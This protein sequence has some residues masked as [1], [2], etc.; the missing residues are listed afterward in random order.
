MVSMTFTDLFGFMAFFLLPF[1]YLN[2]RIHLNFNYEINKPE[3]HYHCKS[4]TVRSDWI[5]L[6]AYTQLADQKIKLRKK[7][8]SFRE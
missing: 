7:L 6:L 8:N 5:T 2:G 1:N 4:I 3:R